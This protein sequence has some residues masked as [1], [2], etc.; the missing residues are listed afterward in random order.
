[1]VRTLFEQPFKIIKF[2]SDNLREI[3]TL[4]DKIYL[5]GLTSDRKFLVKKEINE[6]INCEKLYIF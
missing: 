1:M 5:L 2:G 4:K 3:L 6:L